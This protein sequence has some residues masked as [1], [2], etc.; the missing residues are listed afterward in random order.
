M[1]IHELDMVVIA[2]LD[3]SHADIRTDLAA[4]AD[5]CISFE[6]RPRIEDGVAA[7]GNRRVYIGIIGVNDGDA[8]GHEFIQ[9]TLAQDP[10]G[11]GHLLT[12][13]YTERFRIGRCGKG[14]D[15]LA[16]R[17]EHADDIGQI[18]FTL[19][20]V[21]G[22]VVKHI[23][24][25]RHIKTVNAGVYFVYSQFFRRTVFLFD[26]F[27]DL[28][29]FITDDAAVSRRI[30]HVRRQDR[31]SCAALFMTVDK[32]C[33]RFLRDQRRIATGDKEGASFTLEQ[34]FGLQ[35]S[36][37]CAELFFLHDRFGL[38]TEVIPDRFTAKTD[39]DD[40][41]LRPGCFDS[42]QYLFDHRDTADFVQNL[43]ELR[44]HTRPLAGSEDKC[45]SIFHPVIASLNSITI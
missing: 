44:L 26:D 6:D 24:Q 8:I 23:P 34:R 39:D 11:F 33:K 29:F 43:G 14:T 45:N 16:C 36:V 20:I 27:D 25:E 9:F 15:D 21:I 5:D 10:F 32:G 37:A 17:Y 31:R 2:H 3:V 1:S 28:P 35:D 40:L 22:D 38:V 13:V 4:F 12:R 42:P 30:R 41:A 19:G 7:D 18:I